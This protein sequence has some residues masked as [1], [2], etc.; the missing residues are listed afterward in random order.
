MA[1]SSFRQLIDVIGKRVGVAHIEQVVDCEALDGLEFE[2]Q[3]TAIKMVESSIDEGVSVLVFCIFGVPPPQRELSALR[4]LM[5][6]N[7]FLSHDGHGMFGCDPDSGAVTFRFEHPLAALHVEALMVTLGMIAGQ[8]AEWRLSLFLD[9]E[10]D[11]SW[12]NGGRYG[13]SMIPARSE[14]FPGQFPGGAESLRG[15][16]RRAS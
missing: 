6:I 8:A 11:E 13:A 16:P 9:D 3:G 14:L 7:L 5:E 4:R 2:Y 10:E 12:L 1:I 15:A